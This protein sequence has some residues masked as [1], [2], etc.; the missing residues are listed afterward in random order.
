M[1]IY[2]D[3]YA[4]DMPQW[5][6]A[7]CIWQMQYIADA[8]YHG[9]FARKMLKALTLPNKAAMKAAAKA[10]IATAKYADVPFGAMEPL[11]KVRNELSRSSHLLLIRFY[12]GQATG[13]RPK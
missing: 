13:L 3:Q 4:S 7:W 6:R 10:V 9:F 5:L 8:S 1:F 11:N 2:P 12:D